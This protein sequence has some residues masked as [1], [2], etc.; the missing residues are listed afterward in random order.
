M[1]T[2]KVDWRRA[3]LAESR[4]FQA[5]Q[6]AEIDQVLAH[7]VVRRVA[8]NR[9]ILRRGDASTGAY[10]IV[11][12]RVRVS[13]TSENGR[14][15][16][17]GVL[18]PREIL[19]EMSVL[20]GDE[21]SADAIA[22]EDCVLLLIER[23]RFRNLLRGSSDLCLRLMGVLCDRLRRSN[24]SFEDMALQDLPGRLG[25][26]LLRFAADY[27]AAGVRG[28]RIELKLSQKD[29]STLVGGSREKVNRQLRLWQGQGVLGTENGRLVILRPDAL[30]AGE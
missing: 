30:T 3:A 27:G 15:A 13:V 8:R 1:A 24:V 23:A 18:G 6:P 12:G 7:A 26:L 21:V 11:T 25:R 29:L 22:L 17:L 19:G 5:L 2:M 28:T 4:M 20:D 16:T 10:V 14:E 9:T